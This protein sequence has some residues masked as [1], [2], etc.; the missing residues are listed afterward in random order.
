M[1]MTAQQLIRKAILLKAVDFENIEPFSQ[2]LDG[3]GIDKLY[4]SYNEYDELNDPKNEIR[5][6][7]VDANLSAITWSRS[8]EID[9][10]AMKIDGVWVAW[11]FYYGG[12]KHGEPES[13]DWISNARIVNCEEIQVMT[14]QYDFSE[15]K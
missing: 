4:E 9:V 1:S 15:I 14:T 8:Y 5:Y 11:D 7:Q 12:G 13:F 2:S 6:G 10:R 3:A